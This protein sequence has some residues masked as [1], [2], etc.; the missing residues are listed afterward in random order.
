VQRYDPFHGP[1]SLQT[2]GET[3]FTHLGIIHMLSSVVYSE[4]VQKPTQGCFSAPRRGIDIASS[5]NQSAGFLWR[6]SWWQPALMK[7]TTTRVPFEESPH[8]ENLRIGSW[9]WPVSDKH[10]RLSTPPAPHQPAQQKHQP[11]YCPGHRTKDSRFA[12][13][14]GRAYFSFHPAGEQ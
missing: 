7:R 12:R 11:G 14:K 6:G 9:H 4:P 10:H 13:A 3:S 8:S 1:Q 5:E 2:F